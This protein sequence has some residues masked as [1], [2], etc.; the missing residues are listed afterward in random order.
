MPFSLMSS[1]SLQIPSILW[2]YSSLSTTERLLLRGLKET[3]RPQIH[4]FWHSL[5]FLF[6]ILKTVTVTRR[7]FFFATPDFQNFTQILTL[8][9]TAAPKLRTGDT[10][11]QYNTTVKRSYRWRQ[12]KSINHQ[13]LLFQDQDWCRVEIGQSLRS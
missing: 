4:N 6:Q 5:K 10:S 12:L 8:P 3:P 13:I 9:F 2:R 11:W 7:A 1:I